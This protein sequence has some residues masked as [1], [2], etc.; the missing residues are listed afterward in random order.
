MT[1]PAVKPCTVGLIQPVD[2]VHGRSARC[3]PG[4]GLLGVRREVRA[5]VGVEARLVEELPEGSLRRLQ[6]SWW[7]T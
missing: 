7:G 3:W 5:V 2:Q 1:L 4:D 6:I